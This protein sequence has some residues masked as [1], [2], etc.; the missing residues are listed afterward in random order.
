MLINIWFS[1]MFSTPVKFRSDHTISPRK[2]IGEVM[3]V[4]SVIKHLMFSSHLS[5]PL[6]PVL[7]SRGIQRYD[8][9]EVQKANLAHGR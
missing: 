2:E 9:I 1:S 5:S 6:F 7:R 3:F 8:E 4:T